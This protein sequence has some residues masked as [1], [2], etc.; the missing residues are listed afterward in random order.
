[1][2]RNEEESSSHYWPST[3]AASND[4]QLVKKFKDD[5]MLGPETL[6]HFPKFEENHADH[7]KKETR[8]HDDADK[9]KKVLNAK[10]KKT[11][12]EELGKEV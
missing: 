9:G 1:M 3:F 8:I 11:S 4:H 6:M 2:F 5:H 10:G 7:A 12:R